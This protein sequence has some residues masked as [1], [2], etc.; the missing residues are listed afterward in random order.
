VSDQPAFPCF[1]NADWQYNWIHRGMSLRDWFAGKAL[2]GLI[3]GDAQSDVYAGE[4]G[5]TKVAQ[6]AY[7]IADAMMKAREVKP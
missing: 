3:A 2:V 7:L 6:D 1:N 5:E 4:H